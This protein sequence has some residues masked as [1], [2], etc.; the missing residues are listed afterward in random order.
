[1]L[2]DPDPDS[3]LDP[4]PPRSSSFRLEVTLAVGYTRERAGHTVTGRWETT[5]VS[6][7]LLIGGIALVLLFIYEIFQRII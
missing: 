7:L 1:M 6:V 4:V 2:S 3:I 5:A